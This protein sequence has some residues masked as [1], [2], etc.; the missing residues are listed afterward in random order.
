MN[1]FRF[2][3]KFMPYPIGPLT[4]S[5]G[6]IANPVNAYAYP[7]YINGVFD[8]IM[9]FSVNQERVFV[10]KLIISVFISPELKI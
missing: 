6:K 8:D 4:L 7:F 1:F 3:E 10:M 5:L 9:W 2:H